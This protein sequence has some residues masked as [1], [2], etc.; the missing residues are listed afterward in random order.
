MI[1]SI[2]LTLTA[3]AMILSSCDSQGT[4]AVTLP[5]ATCEKPSE[6]VLGALSPTTHK[7]PEQVTGKDTVLA[8]TEWAAADSVR[9]FFGSREVKLVFV[10]NNNMFLLTYAG[11][12]PV[13]T[14]LSQ[15]DEGLYGTAGSINSPLFSPDGKKIVF[16][17]TTRGKPGFIQDAVPG[18]AKTWR[19]PLDPHG[20]VTADPHWYVEGGKTYVYFATLAG[21]LN[22]SDGCSQIPGYTYRVEVL[23]D[24]VVDSIRVSGIPGAYRG[25]ISRDGLW[26]GTSYASTALFDKVADNTYLLAGGAQQCNPSMNPYPIGSTHSDYMMILAFGG[27]P[28]Y[29]IIDNTEIVEGLH[30]NLWIYNRQNR[31][32]W[33]AKR[34]DLDTANDANDKNS[35]YLHFDK[36]EWSTDP[37]FATAVVLR[38]ETEVGDLF[39]VKI[40]DLANAEEGKLNQAQGYLRIG[41]GGFTADSFTHLWVA[42]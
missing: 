12:Q 22:Y 23:S 32:V 1:K 20:H 19:V 6:L 28:A 5:E 33:R 36:P 29:K 13:V 8:G 35:V 26:A 17:G 40:G 37:N 10:L 9:A 2:A 4:G 27:R 16:A 18:G 11:D 38:K 30:E 24:T 7:H 31:I 25:G 14:R 42:P 41:K 34:P 39:V 15:G 3:A 21:L